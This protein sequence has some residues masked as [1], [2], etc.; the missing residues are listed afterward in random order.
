MTVSGCASLLGLYA[1]TRN[2][3]SASARIFSAS[4]R[5]LPTTSG[6]FTSGLRKDR[7]TVVAT[8]KRKTTAIAITIAMLRKIDVIL[9]T[10]LT[11][12][13]SLA[14]ELEVGNKEAVATMNM[15]PGA[16]CFQ[17]AKLIVL[18]NFNHALV[19]FPLDRA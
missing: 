16:C 2:F 12:L 7:Y 19:L 8:P 4:N 10:K 18:H 11:K 1:R 9:L 13:R 6:T 17:K 5:F 14:P 3:R 15:W